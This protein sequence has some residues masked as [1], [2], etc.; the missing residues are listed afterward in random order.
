MSDAARELLRYV[1]AALDEHD[2]RIRALEDRQAPWRASV[3]ARRRAAPRGRRAAAR[4]RAELLPDRGG[5]RRWCRP[6][7]ATSPPP[8]TGG[9]RAY[10]APIKSRTRRRKTATGP[11]RNV[12]LM[13]PI[14]TSSDLAPT[15]AEAGPQPPAPLRLANTGRMSPSAQTWRAPLPPLLAAKLPKSARAGHERLVRRWEQ[16]TVEARTAALEADRAHE[17]DNEATREA[18]DSGR[19]SKRDHARRC[20]GVVAG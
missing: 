1:Q 2:R 6:C 7:S 4:E 11:R 14:F 8:R 19:S 10:S 18:P 9:R 5:D 16:A 13:T 17:A 15:V 12:L 20:G 3:R